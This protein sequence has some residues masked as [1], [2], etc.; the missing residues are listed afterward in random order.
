MEQAK[1]ERALCSGIIFW[2]MND[3]WPAS[4]G[5][6][7]I[8]YYNIPK[9]AYYSFKRCAKPVI[10]SIDFENGVYRVYVI[11]DREETEVKVSIKVLSSDRKT[12]REYRTLNILLPKYSSH[13]VFEAEGILADREALICD[14]E[15]EFGRDRAFYLHGGLEIKPVDV[16]FE[17]DELNGTVKVSAKEKYV[18]AVTVSGNA[19]FDD[20]C[21]SLLPYES[22]TFS[23]RQNGECVD[24]C[25]SA[26]AYTLA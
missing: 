4:A 5:W 26:E 1:R 22:R 8:D 14:I 18:H 9:N 7:L 6:S 25:L 3:C 19:V 2:M 15:G 16:S 11:N 24:V 10:S 21:F 17:A 23:Y 12:V 13:F 20:N